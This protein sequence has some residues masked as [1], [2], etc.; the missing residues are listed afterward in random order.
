MSTVYAIAI[1]PNSRILASAWSDK[2][3]RLW[4]LK[5]RQPISSLL[6]HAEIVHCVSFVADGKLLATGCHDTNAYTWDVAVIVMEACLDDLLKPQEPHN[7]LLNRD[8]TQCPVQPRHD[9]C[10]V[11]PGFFD[12]LPHRAHLSSRRR[13]SAPHG[14]TILG[15]ISSSFSRTHSNT[16][17]TPSRRRPL[18]DW[19]RNILSETPHR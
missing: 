4:N 1:S 18:I 8:V 3:A 5:T 10:R 12:D 2:T 14:R 7:A 6:Q 13:S 11:P 19:A 17:N 15:R 9:A 16:H